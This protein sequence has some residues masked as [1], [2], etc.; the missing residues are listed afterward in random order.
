MEVFLASV[1]G[2]DER[3]IVGVYSSKDSAMRGCVEYLLIE[4]MEGEEMMPGKLTWEGDSY[5][6][7]EIVNSYDSLR[8]SKSKVID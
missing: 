6:S 1:V 5:W 7:Y 8:I 4:S 3:S 2:R